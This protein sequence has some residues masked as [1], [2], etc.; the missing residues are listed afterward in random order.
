[1]SGSLLVEVT[2][3][4]DVVMARLRDRGVSVAA[5]RAPGSFAVEI[6]DETVPAAVVAIV[7]ELG[8]GLVRLQRR[9]HHLSEIFEPTDA[10]GGAAS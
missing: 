8:V 7:A 3:Q 6:S 5:S 2:D 4:A 1:M 10:A 9:R